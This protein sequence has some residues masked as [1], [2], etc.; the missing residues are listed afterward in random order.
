M[1]RLLKPV[2]GP[3]VRNPT[4]GRFLSPHADRYGR[5]LS[6]WGAIYERFVVPVEIGLSQ[7]IIESGLNGRARSSAR[8]LGF[9]H[10]M[11]VDRNLSIAELSQRTGLSTDELRRFNPALVKR[12]PKRANVHLPWYVYDAR[13]ATRM[14]AVGRSYF[15][16]QISLPV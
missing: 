15:D 1:E 6:E 10:A 4:R 9:C 16:A 3:V 5:F 14:L 8:A 13:R 11:R 12:V 2:V 7:A